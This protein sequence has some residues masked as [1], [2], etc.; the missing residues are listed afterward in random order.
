MVDD[1]YDFVDENPIASIKENVDDIDKAIAKIEDL[2]STY[3][4][5]HKEM[6][7]LSPNTYDAN[8]LTRF[9]NVTKIIK[10]VLLKNRL[11]L[12]LMDF[13]ETCSNWRTDFRR[14]TGRE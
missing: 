9:T 3:R 14:S 13:W 2:R 1:I 6:K 4:A 7:R 12:S 11:H 8:H 5:L 10:H